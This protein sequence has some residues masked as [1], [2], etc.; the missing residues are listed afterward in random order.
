MVSVKSVSVPEQG[1][2]PVIAAMLGP[3]SLVRFGDKVRVGPIRKLRLFRSFSVNVLPSW[4]RNADQWNPDY[5]V[6]TNEKSRN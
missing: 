5:R 6:G 2:E 1:N 3:Q 4:L